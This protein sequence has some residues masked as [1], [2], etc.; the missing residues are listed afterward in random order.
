MESRRMSFSCTKCSYS[1]KRSYNLK[2]HITQD[3]TADRSPK[4][5]DGQPKRRRIQEPEDGSYTKEKYEETMDRLDG[6][7]QLGDGLPRRRLI[8]RVPK[9][10]HFSAA[11]RDRLHWLP[12]RRRIEFRICMLVRNS[13]SCTAPAYLM[14][15]CL[16]SS[17]VPGRRH[18]RSAGKGDLIVP[19]F[20]RE[21]SGRRGFSV[22]GPC[23][24]NSLPPT[25]RCLADQPETFKK[26]LKT[27]F[28]QQY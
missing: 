18:L 3:H 8:L 27:Y 7:S 25:I 15:L 1:T 11:I 6:P 12:V 24:W 26:A 9:Y 20:R 14:D 17:S 2:R 4:L 22:A 23:C 28:M 21:R 19:S 16:P 10:G 5:E 13:L